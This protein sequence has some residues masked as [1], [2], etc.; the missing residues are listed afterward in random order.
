MSSNQDCNEVLQLL[1]SVPERYLA[2]MKR[3]PMH[4]DLAR[5]LTD[6]RA[7]AGEVR[8]LKIEPDHLIVLVVEGDP[9]PFLTVIKLD[10][11]E[12]QRH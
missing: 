10:H 3:Q 6:M 4:P 12:H 1:A 9:E 7:A 11:L 8:V 5:R 2:H